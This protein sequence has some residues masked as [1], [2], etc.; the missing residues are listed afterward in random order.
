ASRRWIARADR[1]ARRGSGASRTRRRGRAAVGRSPVKILF[2]A[3]HYSYL[4][5][6][7]SAIAALAARGHE[8]VL[9]ADREEALGGRGMVERIAAAYPNVTLT[10]AP[11]RHA[12]AWSELARRLRLG[13]D[14]LRF[15]DPRYAG[16]PHL[17]RRSRDRA[18]RSIV[19]LAESLGP[20][21]MGS[22][23]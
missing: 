8:I 17:R 13:L 10:E 9:A 7:E 16:T 5:L 12:G 3:R 23:L 15:L 2:I 14:Y 19:R 6:F 4:R 21:V 11:G 1:R 20:G 18:P 22:V